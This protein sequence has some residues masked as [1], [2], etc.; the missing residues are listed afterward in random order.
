MVTK[1]KKNKWIA[2]IAILFF[3]L[4]NVTPI[5]ACSP[6]LV[7]TLV[8]QTINGTNLELMWSSN[9]TYDCQYIVQVELV[10]LSGSFT[11]TGTNPP[12]LISP[13]INKLGTPYAYPVQIIDISKL[14]PGT[15]YQ[16]RA[17]E[18]EQLSPTTT[19]S[20]TS[21]FTF[22]TPGVFVAP[23]LT[24]TASPPQICI[25]QTSQLNAVVA[26]GCG[27]AAPTYTWQPS[28]GLSNASIA[29]PIA[30]PVVTT[31]YTCYVNSDAT[32]CWSLN[33]T[34]KIT[35]GSFVTP[36]AASISP[37]PVCVG[38]PGTLKLTGSSGTIQ[39]QS[40]PSSSGP[41]TDIAGAT[42][43]PYVT[44]PI[45]TKT[46]FQAVVTG[47]GTSGISSVICADVSG[48]L[49][50]TASSPII[51]CKGQ[52]TLI[53]AVGSGGNGGPY[54]YSWLPIGATGSTVK[55]SPGATIT[56]T[57]A[58]TDACNTAPSTATVDITVPTPTVSF[59]ATN[60]AGCSPLIVTFT[61]TTLHVQNCAWDFGDS[62]QSTSCAT[63]FDHTYTAP[64]TYDVA[65]SGDDNNGCPA[66]Q[67]QTN[68]ITVYPTPKSCFST[69]P[70]TASQFE[71][72]INFQNCAK[73]AATWAWSFGDP[74]DSKSTI[75]SPV[76]TYQDTGTYEV[77][78]LVCGINGCCDS[79][80]QNVIITPDYAFY[81]P[82]AFTPNGDGRNEEF[83]PLMR[84]LDPTK[85]NMWIF[86][87]WGREVFATNDY[88]KHWHTK[89][90][91]DVYTWKVEVYDYYAVK[92][93]Y[94]GHVSVIK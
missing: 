9:T 67:T 16:F 73:G 26:N 33:G 40:G 57:V 61:N 47:C 12:Y 15:T 85:Y 39:W 81:I 38:T 21:T 1:N 59:S 75:T 32:G 53:T 68:L 79:S 78:Q 65:F 55:V 30:S 66:S 5:K 72:I 14:C 34:A 94:T 69:T 63:T 56:Y 52:D 29:N 6:L 83:Y 70:Q 2:L 54:I 74:L 49:N 24:V 13:A 48:P 35:V 64:G 46:C 60:I 45:N 8:S 11:G 31:T 23:S 17:E 51:L 80:T 84:N 22:T 25:P 93:E 36:G 10:C 4:V 86:D 43:T 91:T 27:V 82:D 18:A 76:F 88:S 87:R 19:S 44:S 89:V 58:V 41:W 62:K 50:L 20:W 71:P 42:A 3:T 90:E 28:T 77:K 37:N 92:H 7:P